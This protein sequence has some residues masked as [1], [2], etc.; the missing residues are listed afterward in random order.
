M[1]TNSQ[2]NIKSANYR[3]SNIRG[4]ALP[5]LRQM[6]G[7]S[8]KKQYNYSKINSHPQ[9][10]S[11]QKPFSGNP[12]I[13]YHH[14]NHHN[15][16]LGKRPAK[17]DI[18]TANPQPFGNKYY[19]NFAVNGFYNNNNNNFLIHN[20]YNQNIANI[21]QQPSLA[22]SLPRAQGRKMDLFNSINPM[23]YRDNNYYMG[24]YYSGNRTPITGEKI[25]SNASIN[26]NNKYQ[27]RRDNVN[28]YNYNNNNFRFNYNYNYNNYNN[29]YKSKPK[30]EGILVSVNSNENHNN[31][32]NPSHIV[33]ITKRPTTQDKPIKPFVHVT[34]S[35]IQHDNNHNH[36]HNLANTP[37]FKEYYYCEEKNL[38]HRKTMEDFHSA[39]PKFAGDPTKSYFAIFDG[40]SGSSP[41]V[42]C[43]DNLHS[44]LSK[45][46]FN[47]NFNVEK[48]LDITFKRI[49]NEINTHLIQKP[50]VNPDTDNDSVR[51]EPGTT[52]TVVFIFQEYSSV[53]NQTNRVLY[54]ANVGDS[55]C[56]LIKSN[57][58]PIQISTDHNCLVAS[59]VTRIRDNGGIVFGGR[60]FGTLML[61]RSIGD[62]EMKKY[63]VLPKPSIKRLE[64][65][66][67][68]KWVVLAS[69]G[70]W[71]VVNEDNLRDI[72]RKY[73]NAERFCKEIVKYAI[74]A[75]S[76][77][78]ISCIVIKL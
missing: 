52:A 51:V 36:S 9:Q 3:K 23:L 43:K 65:G 55:K 54:C 29:K 17:R 73:D 13:K 53:L 14:N 68:D 38:S 66:N 34:P 4:I 31:N 24:D 15:M 2:H 61:T 40:H 71:D 47:T 1:Q 6:S 22:K 10:R 60:V 77:D 5:S 74:D 7:V 37:S 42:Y 21:Y 11:T 75:D 45:S 41:A 33:K 18:T 67:E 19:N 72:S 44:Y 50:T 64:I 39:I 16:T 62:K 58:T 12:S 30:K 76:R 48:S 78:N 49:D 59:E 27:Q 20:C 28:N 8:N 46:L 57:G 56:F 35:S 70:V 32:N 63:G 25:V 26:N 69:D